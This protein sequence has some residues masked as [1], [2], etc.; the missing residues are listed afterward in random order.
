LPLASLVM[1]MFNW[2]IAGT[3]IKIYIGLR[4]HNFEGKPLTLV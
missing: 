4:K 1:L 3:G 2:N